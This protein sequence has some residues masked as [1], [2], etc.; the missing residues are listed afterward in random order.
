MGYG[1]YPD[2]VGAQYSQQASQTNFNQQ[3][4][5]PPIAGVGNPPMAAASMGQTCP[6][7]ATSLES[8]LRAEDYFNHLSRWTTSKPSRLRTPPVF[9]SPKASPMP[10]RPQTLTH[11]RTI[12]T[13]LHWQ[14]SMPKRPRRKFGKL[15]ETR[16]PSCMQTT[17]RAATSGLKT[18]FG[19]NVARAPRRSTADQGE[20]C[21]GC[22]AKSDRRAE[23]RRLRQQ[24]EAAAADAAAALEAA[25]EQ[26]DMA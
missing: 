19:T 25:G 10:T 26:A 12:P 6:P 8:Q 9:M 7:L 23:A 2:V 5:S 11:R 4:T 20:L 15:S 18:V 17:T 22:K 13:F 16:Q 1:G 24:E 14:P 3:I 21:A